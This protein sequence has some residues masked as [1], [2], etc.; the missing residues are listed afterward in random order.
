[1]KKIIVLFVMSF[2]LL[3]GLTHEEHKKVIKM[4]KDGCLMNSSDKYCICQENFFLTYVPFEDFEEVAK[5]M[6]VISK[7]PT[8][9]PKASKKALFFLNGLGNKCYSEQK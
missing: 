4:M 8:F 3:F 5:T 1:M 6:I 7:D 9:A 2:S